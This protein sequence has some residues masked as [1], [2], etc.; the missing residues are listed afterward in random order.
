MLKKKLI[1]LLFFCF[2][3]FAES[4]KACQCPLTSL[5]LDECAKYEII[6]RGRVI[7]N[8]TCN[9]KPGESVFEIKEL[10]KGKVHAQF[11]VLYD[12]NTECASSFNEGE[13]WII[14]TN[15]KQVDNARM[16]WCSRS[17][18]Y[19]KN[20]KEDFYSVTYGN[21]Y[22]DELLFLR[23]NLGTY[24]VME[25]KTEEMPGHR[26]IIPSMSQLIITLFISLAVVVL[27]LYLFNKYFR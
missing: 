16:D 23:K 26:N 18:K 24:K 8:T 10:F 21:N 22:D 13:E 15:Y 4:L 14:Y 1:S 2:L 11:T 12:C 9:S 7:K 3:F 27:F 25:Q 5:S 17:R 6:F 19:F 20:E